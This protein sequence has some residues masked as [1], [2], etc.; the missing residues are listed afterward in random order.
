MATELSRLF[1]AIGAKTDEFHKGIDGVSN[2]LNN[3]SRQMK[4]AGGIMVGAVAAIGTASLKMAGDFDGAMR[5]VNTMMLLSENEFKDF[6]K[7]VQ[8][9]AKDMGINAVEAANALY[10]AIS[11]GVPK[12]NAIEFLEIASKAAI[13]GVTDTKTAVDGL[14]TVINAFKLPM[15]DAQKVADIMFTTVKGGKT[16]FD[17]LAASMFNVAPMAASAGVKFEDVS[18]ALATMTKQGVPTTQATTQLRQAI[19]AM[20]KP[21][22]EMKSALEGLGYESGEALIAEKGLTGALDALTEASGGS[23]EVLGKMFGSVEGLQAVLSLTGENAEMAARDIDAMTNSAG[24]A[25]DAYNQMEQ[26]TGRQLEKLKV[27]FQDIAITIGTALM[28]VLKTLLDTI[29]PIV[30]KVGEWISEHPKLTAAILGAVGALGALLLLAGPLLKTIQLMSLALHSQ[31]IAFIAHKVALIAAS[32]VTKIAAAAQWLLNAAMSANPIG[33]IILA[34]AGLVAAIVWMIQNWDTVVEHLKK[35]WEW[36]K[37]AFWAV[38]NFFKEALG[39][40]ADFFTNI[41]EG[42]ANFL[43]GIWDKIT[44]VF[45]AA[46]DGLVN[47]VK[48]AVN[49]VLGIINSLITGFEGAINF[50]I[51]GVNAFIGLMNKP[52]ELLNKIPGVNLPLIP[53]IGKITLPRIPL[54]DVGGLIEGPGLFA[55]GRGVKEVIREPG[56]GGTGDNNFYISEMVVR[57]EADIQK[58]ARELYRLQQSKQAAKGI[59]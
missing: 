56:V 53:T 23:N 5:E 33:L 45:K 1:V 35:I 27:Q 34:I 30:T 21:T 18:A 17:E 32:V 43:K 59:A 40:I 37:T 9:L 47:I 55:V 28:P 41:F 39:A 2:K 3:V 8:N 38:V 57:E 36:M 50:V 46:W 48:S 7:E 12:E 4:I 52:I 51:K 54:L 13:G 31:T 10:Q 6:S 42:I 15:S 11:A 14:T 58:I 26:S 20:I 25:T 22:G 29:M 19:Q 49:F 24:A 44:G 16:T